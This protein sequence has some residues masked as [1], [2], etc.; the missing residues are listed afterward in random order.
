MKRLFLADILTS[1][2][3]TVQPHHKVEQVLTLMREQK[4]SAVVVTK[5]KYP[6]GIFTERDAVRIVGRG[7]DPLTV[8]IGE[9]M[10]HPIYS[11]PSDMEYREAYYL[12]AEHGYRHLVVVDKEGKLAGI[13]SEGDFMRNLGMEFLLRIKEVGALMAKE[14]QTLSPDVKL[15]DA[16]AL[17]DRRRLS[18]IVVEENDI[19]IGMVTERDIV[20]MKDTSES[21][22]Q[23]PLCE[24]MTHPVTTV[25]SEMPIP[26]AME[27]MD[28]ENFRRVV[29]VD[30]K[31]HTIGLLT[32]HDIVHQV[33]N[34]HVELLEESLKA[35]E[36]KLKIVTEELE[37]E[38]RQHV[39]E[40]RLSESQRLAHIGSWE[41]DIVSNKFWFSDETYRIFQADPS[42]V[43]VPY[44]A[45]LNFIHPQ[46]RE[47]ADNA[48]NDSILNQTPHN[49]VHRIQLDDGST[50]YVHVRSTTYYDEEG[51]PLRSVGTVQDITERYEQEEEIERYHAMLMA[52]SKESTDAIFVKDTKGCYVLGNEALAR[53]LNKPLEEIIGADDYALF[54]SAVDA[55]HF[56]ADDLR[57]QKN[58]TVETYEESV[59][60]GN[61]ILPY[62]TTKGPLYING[63]VEGVFGIARDISSLKQAE[64][65]LKEREKHYK[66]LFERTGTSMA[67][68]ER[69]GTFS[70]IN[71]T[72]V[73][74][75]ETT[76]EALK[77]KHFSLFLDEEDAER[78]QA[79][80]LARIRGENV[81]VQYEYR[82]KTAKGN[83]GTGLMTAVYLPD[84]EQTVISVIDIS[85]RVMIETN[86]KTLFERTGTCMGIVEQDG[87]FS[88]VNETFAQLAESS[89][90]VLTGSSFLDLVH[91]SEKER[92]Q[93]YHTCRM[94]GE[95][96]PE[97]YAFTFRSKK[98]NLGTG[99]LYAVFLPDTQQTIVSII[100]ISEQKRAEEALHEQTWFLE[101]L[102]AVSQVLTGEHD[103]VKLLD[104]L[105]ALILEIFH[106]DRAW[107]L[108][109]CDPD[110]TEYAVLAESTQNGF[111][112][113]YKAELKMPMDDITATLFTHA[114]AMDRP[115]I[116]QVDEQED[117][118]DFIR[119]FKIQS[120][121]AMALHPQIGDAWLM[122]LHQCSKKRE[123]TDIEMR[124][125]QAIAERIGSALSN[126]LLLKQLRENEKVL[127]EAE[128]TAKLGHWELDIATGKAQW[129]DEIHRITGTDSSQEVGPAFL[130]SIVNQEDWPNLKTSLE[131]A[132]SQGVPHEMEYRVKTSRWGR[133][134]AIL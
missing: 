72:A 79:Y 61:K 128:S 120:Q 126:V 12:I 70:L 52:L 53:L 104:S 49:L 75:L 87:R 125:Y 17:M 93:A 82:F 48:Y 3:T 55:E 58:K 91:P 21:M 7:Y 117:V 13:V 129:S 50:K 90:E 73:N 77:G 66:I 46:D 112:G 45:Y 95:K 86:Y 127:L 62:Q 1:Y 100:D 114:L 89:R 122:G 102:D 134:L 107:F 60:V 105:S 124:L 101:S 18:C 67:I 20:R 51:T 69:D 84:S 116:N 108:Y 10:S 98:G 25:R 40:S 85:K 74:L 19:P 26:E 16:V 9:V 47:M 81:P 32:R 83:K 96:A 43:T 76:R 39:L 111:D 92:I 131:T 4:I 14:V 31:G 2:V 97:Y 29:V 71:D 133:A 54:T 78:V 44:E 36:T 37:K 115:I 64:K 15:K 106:V 132:A 24:V 57:I 109:P 63:N 110:T 88:L 5:D 33:Y 119:E 56:R 23:M 11:V 118:P 22:L 27:I 30:E 68:V 8:E 121:M 123:W 94:Q 103:S 28:R 42:E 65:A 38:R 59:T 130:S 35:H 80:Y 6:V 99:L 34:R 113:A 41:L